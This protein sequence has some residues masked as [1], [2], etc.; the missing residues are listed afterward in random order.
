MHR[1]K[2]NIEN[3]ERFYFLNAEDVNDFRSRILGQKECSLKELPNDPLRSA[4]I[5]PV[6]LLGEVHI[7]CGHIEEQMSA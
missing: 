4:V 2:S 3:A 6:E 5:L 1:I 7:K